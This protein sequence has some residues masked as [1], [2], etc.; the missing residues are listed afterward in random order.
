MQALLGDINIP[1]PGVLDFKGKTRWEA[2]DE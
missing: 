1:K 2:W